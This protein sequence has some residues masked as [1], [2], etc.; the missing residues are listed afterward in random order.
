MAR[1]PTTHG[2]ARVVSGRMWVRTPYPEMPRDSASF[3]RAKP[4]PDGHS[5]SV[6]RYDACFT[7][8]RRMRI[9]PTKMQTTGGRSRLGSGTVLVVFA[10]ALAS[11]A[12]CF[13]YTHGT[14]PSLDAKADTMPTREVPDDD[15]PSLTPAPGPDTR[16]D[17]GADA[18]PAAAPA[19]RTNAYSCGGNH[20]AGATDTLYR[21]NAG[22]SVTLIAKCANGCIVK[23]PL[24]DDTCQTPTPCV[25][26]GTYCGGDKINGDPDVLY[27]CGDGGSTSV[28]KRCPKGCTVKPSPMNDVCTP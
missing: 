22:G 28:N 4:V 1:G 24:E 27:T 19:C 3:A 16:T 21:C 20:V 8:R 7:S 11:N 15:G 5:G 2:W 23:A 26:G 6:L 9:H 12:G 14:A 17:A 10:V 18:T 25:F 13:D